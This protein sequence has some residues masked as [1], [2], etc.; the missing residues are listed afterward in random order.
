VLPSSGPVAGTSSSPWAAE[1]AGGWAQALGVPLFEH[2]DRIPSTNDYLR[3]LAVTGAPIFTT[4]VARSQSEGRGRGGKRWHSAQDCG[5]WMSILLPA[6]SRGSGAGVGVL[7]LA[8]GVAAARAVESVVAGVEVGL[9]WPND[10]LLDGWKF[11]GILCEAVSGGKEMGGRD[12]LVIAG[13]GINLRRPGDDLPEEMGEGVSFLEEVAE[14]PVPEPLVAR[15]LV[16]ELRRWTEPG[17]HILDGELRREWEAR[18]ILRGRQ[19]RVQ[20][21]REEVGTARGVAPGGALLL[22]GANGEIDEIWSGTIR[23]LE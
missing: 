7:P 11:G 8:V 13:V 17:P 23:P 19:V 14:G 15:A 21:G 9:K 1:P 6:P 4:V 12:S 16:T 3:R 18:D 10:L 5:L 20:G 22:E 2:H